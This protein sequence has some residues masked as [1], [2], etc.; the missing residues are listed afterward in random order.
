M[1]EKTNVE[2]RGPREMADEQLAKLIEEHRKTPTLDLARQIAS[3]F[4]LLEGP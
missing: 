1:L 3:L 4:T 2:T